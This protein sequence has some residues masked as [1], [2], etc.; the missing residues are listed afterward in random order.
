MKLRNAHDVVVGD[1]AL[2]SDADIASALKD[3]LMRYIPFANERLQE[4]ER[5]HLGY[6]A[7]LTTEERQQKEYDECI[8]ALGKWCSECMHA[9]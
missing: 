1:V 7:P 5:L 9:M 3:A 8:F 4:A 6:G 2:V